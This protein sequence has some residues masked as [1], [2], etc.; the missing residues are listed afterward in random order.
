MKFLDNFANFKAN[1]MRIRKKKCSKNCK[2]IARM[3]LWNMKGIMKNFSEKFEQIYE[4]GENFEKLQNIFE[5]ILKNFQ[6]KFMKRDRNF[7]E[8]MRFLKRHC[9]EKSGKFWIPIIINFEKL[10]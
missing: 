7:G 1:F 6:A 2:N 5:E 3:F 4:N 9:E 8:T 10:E